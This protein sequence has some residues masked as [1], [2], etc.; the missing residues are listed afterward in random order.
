MQPHHFDE[1]FGVQQRLRIIE[2]PALAR[3]HSD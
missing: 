3:N 1:T 2:R